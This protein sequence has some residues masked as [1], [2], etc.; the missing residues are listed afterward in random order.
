MGVVQILSDRGDRT[1]FGSL[2]FSISGFFWV[3]KFWQ[4]FFGGSLLQV[5][6]FGGILKK[7]F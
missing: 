4:V 7:C 3:V 6:I 1:I 5:G 2:K